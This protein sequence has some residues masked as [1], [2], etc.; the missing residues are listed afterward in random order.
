VAK[1]VI[2]N[3]TDTTPGKEN[4]EFTIVAKGLITDKNQKVIVRHIKDGKKVV[5]QNL[6][7][8]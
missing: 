8:Q 4:E 5:E 2:Y 3:A 6:T 7:I 1:Q